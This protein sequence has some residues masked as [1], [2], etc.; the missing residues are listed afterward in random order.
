[1]IFGIGLISVPNS[2]SILCRANLQLV[3]LKK[4][5]IIIICIFNKFVSFDLKNFLMINVGLPIVISDE[6]N[7]NT[8]VTESA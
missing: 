6:I 5:Y 7:G 4:N 8:Q 3:K 1:M 2:D